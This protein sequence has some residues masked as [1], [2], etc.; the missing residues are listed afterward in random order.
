MEQRKIH[1][2]RLDEVM[3]EEL[4]ETKTTINAWCPVC[5]EFLK[6]SYWKH[7]GLTSVICANCSENILEEDLI[8]L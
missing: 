1:R 2:D 3:A 5:D 6:I 7:R 4:E 8:I